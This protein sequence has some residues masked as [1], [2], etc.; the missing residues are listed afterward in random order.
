MIEVVSI[1]VVFTVVV[2]V[3]SDSFSSLWIMGESLDN[4]VIEESSL[5]VA[6]ILVDLGASSAVVVVDV[7]EVE[8]SVVD[9]VIE[10][11]SLNVVRISVVLAESS[12]DVI[13]VVD[14]VDVV[15]V[16]VVFVIVDVEGS[17]VDVVIEE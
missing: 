2:V 16:G 15:V 6:R 3:S 5:K 17:V 7:V 8:D 1:V 12:V 10:E 13:V 9:V 11:S 4:V 14:V